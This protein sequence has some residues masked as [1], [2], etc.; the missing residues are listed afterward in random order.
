MLAVFVNNRKVCAPIVDLDV[1]EGW[2]E[3]EDFSLLK[4]SPVQH[5]IVGDSPDTLPEIQL[6][7]KKLFGKVSVRVI[8]DE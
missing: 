5:G 2:V 7:S 8:P 6:P 1:H 4:D 3:I